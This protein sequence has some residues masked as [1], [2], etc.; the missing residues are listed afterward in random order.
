VF[1]EYCNGGTL[2]ELL[3]VKKGRFTESFCQKI[4]SQIK[5]AFVEMQ[6]HCIVHRDIKAANIMLNFDDY[7]GY[8]TNI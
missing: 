7:Q 6:N 4:A 3:K 8:P 2:E 1:I 5:D